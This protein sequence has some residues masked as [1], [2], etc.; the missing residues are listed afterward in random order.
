MA[1]KQGYSSD[2]IA[3]DAVHALRNQLW[4]QDLEP[5]LL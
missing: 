5:A 4:Q 1:L 2:L 3:R